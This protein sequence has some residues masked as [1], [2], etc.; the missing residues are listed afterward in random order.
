M[1]EDVSAQRLWVRRVLGVASPDGT[2]P[3]SPDGAPGAPTQPRGSK[4]IYT[5]ARLQYDAARKQVSSGIDTLMAAIRKQCATEPDFADI[6]SAIGEFA[7]L[8]EALDE[9]LLDALDA[10]YTATT[11]DAEASERAKAAAIVA[12]YQAFY[13][14]HARLL[15]G[16]DANPF[17]PVQVEHV[18]TDAL[19]GLA[20]QLG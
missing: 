6:D 9:R 17:V 19:T 15:T 14:A 13:V 2:P 7:V 20:A 12:E 16:L 1:S 5:Q 3:V 18:L 4:V 11:P 8:K 10:A